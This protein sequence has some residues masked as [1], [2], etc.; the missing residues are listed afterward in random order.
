VC[1][2]SK[3]QAA[4]QLRKLGL[5]RGKGSARD[6]AA[7]MDRD[8]GVRSFAGTVFGKNPLLAHSSASQISGWTGRDAVPTDLGHTAVEMRRG[9]S[10]INQLLCLS[11]VLRIAERWQR[12]ER[13]WQRS[14]DCIRGLRERVGLGRQWTG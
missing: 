8:S 7:A 3:G 1:S 13:R 11:A 5:K 4:S 9:T 6:D 12:Q 10:G 2:M 14:P